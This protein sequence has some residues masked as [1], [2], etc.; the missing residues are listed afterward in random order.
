MEHNVPPT[1]EESIPESNLN[2][3]NNMESLL[4]QQ[5]LDIDF[6]AS[7]EIRTGVIASITPGQI[8]VSIGTKSEGVITGKELEAIPADEMAKLD[9]RHGNPCLRYQS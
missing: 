5:G 7:G 9:R 2:N 1:G 3:E 6:P 8:L 4:N